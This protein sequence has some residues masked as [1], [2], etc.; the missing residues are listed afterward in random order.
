MGTV[1]ETRLLRPATSGSAEQHWGK[2]VALLVVGYLCMTRSFAY[3]GLPWF[4]IYI[5][6]ISLAAFLLFGPT[7]RQGP[8]LRVVQRAKRLRRF[9]WLLLLLL[10][11]GAFEA[12]RGALSGYPIF[13]ALRDTAFNYYPLFLFLGVWVGLHDRQFLRRVIRALAWCNGCYGLAY[14]LLLNRLPLAMPGTAHAGTRVPIFGQPA[15][16]A[17]ALLGMI[18]LEPRLRKVWYLL[19]LNAFVMLGIQVRAEWLGFAVGLLVFAW[20]TKRLRHA[21]AFGLLLAA[22][23]GAMYLSH[24]AIPSPKGR[25]GG[26]ISVRDI[27][28]RALAPIDKSLAD[29]LAPTHDV[30]SFAGTAAWRLVW[31]AAIWHRVNASPSS[32]ALGTGYGYPIGSLNPDIE[33][34]TFIQTPHNDFLYALF[35]SGWFGATLFVLFQVEIL[36][37]L[38]RTFVITGL[39]AGLTLWSMMVT[40]SLFG[41][42]FETPFGAIP[43]YLL[44]GVALAPALLRAYA[45]TPSS[46]ATRPS[47]PAALGKHADVRQGNA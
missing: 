25:S 26:K 44:V 9:E 4:S 45:D 38:R 18:T 13:T 22:L 40:G 34:G 43:F 21:V 10:L 19:V 46:R 15:G 47:P 31:W 8:W 29:K 27:T 17:I 14:I 42:F 33:A 36:R 11:D 28:A 6:E 3:L 32:A 7:T 12:A 30:S 24:F 5:G 2:V 41:D 1:W 23:V 16:S 35:Y 37:L 20:L 39:P